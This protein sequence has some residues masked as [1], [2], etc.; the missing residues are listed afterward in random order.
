VQVQAARS[1]IHYTL[2]IRELFDLQA[3]LDELEARL[4]KR[5]KFALTQSEGT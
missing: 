3:R 2:R 4:E 1:I 5:E